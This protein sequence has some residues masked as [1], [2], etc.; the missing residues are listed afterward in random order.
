M[1]CLR[2]E[3]VATRGRILTRMPHRT[4]LLCIV[5]LLSAL[6]A[7]G[8]A[9][10]PATPGSIDLRGSVYTDIHAD[11]ACDPAAGPPELVGITL[12]FRDATGGE[13]GQATTGSLTT[14]ELPK[15]PGTETWSHGGCRFEAPYAVLLPPADTYAVEFT[16]P[17][18][19][20]PGGGYFTGTD[21][22]VP[23]SAG[24]ADLVSSGF[25]WSFEV[26]PEYVVP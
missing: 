4:R 2:T 19:A 8:G 13:I 11:M 25:V 6:G 7:C 23:Q 20:N 5:P 21:H 17:E 12:T 24:H 14:S 26:P 15:G 16:V 18:P 1:V 22:L 9:V 3:P 10:G